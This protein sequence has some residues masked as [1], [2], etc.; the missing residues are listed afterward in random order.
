[1]VFFFHLSFLGVYTKKIVRMCTKTNVY[2]RSKKMLASRDAFTNQIV[3]HVYEG[4]SRD[5]KVMLIKL[6]PGVR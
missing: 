1:M 6:L 4:K 5:R 3:L 2:G